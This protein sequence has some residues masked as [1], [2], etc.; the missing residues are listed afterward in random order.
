M[1]K[2]FKAIVDGYYGYANY[3]INEILN[4]G[5]HNYFYWLIAA[6]LVIWVL[7]LV[8]P[9]RK[10][11]PAIRQDF[12]M[13]L[14]YLFWNYF[15][16]ALIAYN[17]LSMVAV[18]VFNDFLGLFGITNLVAIHI[19][20]WPFWAKIVLIFVVRDFMQWNIHRMYHH[21]G[22]MWEFHKVHH[23]TREMGFAALLR[24]HWMENVIYRTLE[25][26]PLAMIGVGITDFFVVHIF[27]LVTGQLGHA[28]LRIPLGPF[29]YILNGPQ[30]HLWH[31]ARNLPESHPNGFNYG[32]T[33][34]IWDFIFRTNYWPSDDENLPVGLPDEEK[35]PEDFIGQNVEPFQR[36]FGKKKS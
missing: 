35:F 32:I 2:Y 18:E 4:P 36:I 1:E 17:A 14:F 9:W 25:Y 22:W 12:W 6:S 3:L 19:E 27:T 5:W 10:D 13:D 23:S 15:L 7:E 29:K 26:L 31:H 28:N 34:S 8:F 20:T 30:M 33:L 16:F 24:Y 21:V 11:Q